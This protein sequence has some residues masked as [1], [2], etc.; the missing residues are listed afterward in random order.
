[1]KNHGRLGGSVIRGLRRAVWPLLALASLG[2]AATGCGSGG[3]TNTTVP[4]SPT[5]SELAPVHGK[6]QPSID[7][8][9]F[10]STIDNRYLPYKPGTAL[11]YTGVAEN[12]KTP[13]TTDV[14]VTSRTRTV[15]GVKARV[16]RDNVSQGG[17]QIQ[18]TFDWVAQDKGGNVWYLGEHTYD[19][20]GGHWVKAIDSGPA[21]Q[22]GAEPGI[23][24]PGAP[25]AGE[26]YRQY[27]WPKHAVDESRVLGMKKTLKVPAGTF[28]NVLVTIETSALD[29]GVAEKKYNAPGVGV[30]KEQVVRGNHERFDLARMRRS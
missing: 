2:L 15:L 9:N 30:V 1:M 3:G 29:P 24:M 22:R 5:A 4:A 23:L 6:Y 8:A 28:K 11:H 12:G 13:Q 27:Y 26:A 21:G 25:K 18:R 7:P 16:I 10:V 20:K 14:T 17:R 19:F